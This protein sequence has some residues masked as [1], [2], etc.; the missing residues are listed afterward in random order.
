MRGSLRGDKPLIHLASDD[1]SHL[2]PQGEKG[3]FHRGILW[4]TLSLAGGPR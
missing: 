4:S 2:L 1:A 3:K